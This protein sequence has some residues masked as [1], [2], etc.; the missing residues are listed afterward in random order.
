ML[1]QARAGISGSLT[2]I[3]FLLDLC[4]PVNCLTFLIFERVVTVAKPVQNSVW[5]RVASD[6]TVL[7][8]QL[9]LQACRSSWDY[10]RA[11]AAEITGVTDQL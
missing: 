11:G 10:R 2:C 7:L 6:S 1:K 8:L 9:G 4:S 3:L 5:T